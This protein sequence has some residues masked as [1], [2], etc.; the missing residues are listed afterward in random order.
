MIIAPPMRVTRCSTQHYAAPAS[1]VFPLLCPVR[2]CDWIPDWRP[3]AVLSN[4]GY[5]ELDCTFVTGTGSERAVWTTTRYDAG[6]GIIEFVRFGPDP[7][8]SRIAI[9]V[10]PIDA[11]ACSVELRYQHTALSDDG[12]AA[13][14]AFGEAEFRAFSDRWQRRLQHYLDTGRMLTELPA[15]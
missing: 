2:E 9:R 4:S 1:T 15:G 12:E 8:I 10:A 7:V 6:K 14:A 13:I 11:A 3:H 5:A